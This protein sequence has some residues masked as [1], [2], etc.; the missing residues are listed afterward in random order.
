MQ[1]RIVKATGSHFVVIGP[2]GELTCR[3]RGKFRLEGEFPLAGDFVEAVPD[4]TAEGMGVIKALLPRKNRLVRPPVA[5]V[6]RLLIVASLAPPV[7]TLTLV[8]Y[9]TALAEYHDI[10]PLICFNKTD[11][12]DAKETAARYRALGYPA[13]AASAKTGEGLSELA[14]ALSDGLTVLTGESGVGKSS[15]LNALSPNLSARTGEI[16]AKNGRGRQ[17]T[18]HVELIPFGNGYVAD[19]PGY[20]SFDAVEMDMTEKERLPWCFVEF[21]EYLGRCKYNDC[22]HVS[23]EG[24]AIL[25]ALQDGHISPSRHESYVRLYDRLKEVRKWELK[26]K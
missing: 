25:Q 24:C 16:S 19:T 11:I 17:T 18:R 15:L 23:D 1:G 2:E 4:G 7:T 22:S 13:V 14:E 9:L 10:V 8:D 3:A 5:N 21:R 26:K 20:S 6:D 12:A